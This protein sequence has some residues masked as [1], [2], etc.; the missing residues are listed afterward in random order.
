MACGLPAVAVDAHG[1]A[2]IVR[3]GETGW[4]VAPDDLDALADALVELVADDAERRR[5]GRAAREDARERFSWPEAAATVA[6]AYASASAP[7]AGAGAD[8]G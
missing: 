5:R 2:E 7:L 1:P 3:D 4:L 6:D 8:T